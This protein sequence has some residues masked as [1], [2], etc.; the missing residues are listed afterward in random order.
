MKAYGGADVYIHVYLTLALVGG[1][2]SASRPDHFTPV[3]RTLGTH[4]IGGWVGPRTGLIS[5]LFSIPI[6]HY[7]NQAL[8]LLKQSGSIRTGNSI[9]R[10]MRQ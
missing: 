3:E 1:E 10:L 8:V 5:A 9:W 6:K 2:R 7:V 4:W